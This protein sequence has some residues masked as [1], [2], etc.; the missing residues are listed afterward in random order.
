M[1]PTIR[2][3]TNADSLTEL[4]TL[5]HASYAEHALAGRR[6]FASYQSVDDTR[7]RVSKG[8]CWLALDGQAMI[9]TVTITVPYS[10]PPGF[11]AGPQVGTFFQFAVLPQ[12]RG[13]GLGHRLLCLAEQRIV[14][15]GVN[16]VVIDTSSLASNLIAWYE[17]RGYLPV[18]RWRWDVTNYE[19]VVLRKRLSSGGEQ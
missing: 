15:V 10:P 7:R 5:L 1:N 16:E 2:Q 11:P 6:F 14:E 18:G 13:T 3:L 9:G 12:Y 17:R 8:E 4:T 19:S